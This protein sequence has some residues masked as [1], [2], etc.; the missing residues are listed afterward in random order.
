MDVV[1]RIEELG[2]AEGKPKEPVLIRRITIE[3]GG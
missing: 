3:G 1:D 2:S